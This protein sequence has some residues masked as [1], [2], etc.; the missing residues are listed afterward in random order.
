MFHL[1]SIDLFN[2]TSFSLS[3]L[4][5]KTHLLLE[6]SPIYTSAFSQVENSMCTREYIH[7]GKFY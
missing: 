2:E 3:S 4:L 6:K 5:F 1:H 7:K